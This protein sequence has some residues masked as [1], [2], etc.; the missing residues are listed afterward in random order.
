MTTTLPFPSLAEPGLTGARCMTGGDIP[1][2]PPAPVGPAPNSLR[3]LHGQA[4]QHLNSA[5]HLFP[6]DQSTCCP[7]FRCSR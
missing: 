3:F 5:P 2:R 7:W 4:T 6:G 1:F